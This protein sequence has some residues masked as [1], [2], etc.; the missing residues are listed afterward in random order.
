MP[1]LAICSRDLH[2]HWINWTLLCDTMEVSMLSRAW[3]TIAQHVFQPALTGRPELISRKIVSGEPGTKAIAVS[4]FR[5]KLSLANWV[6]GAT[7]ISRKIS[8]SW[9]PKKWGPTC[10]RD[11]SNSAIYTTVIY[12]AYIVFCMSFK[13]ISVKLLLHLKSCNWFRIKKYSSK[14]GS[15]YDMV[16]YNTAIMD[17]EYRSNFELTKIHPI[18]RLFRQTVGCLL[19]LCWKRLTVACIMWLHCTEWLVLG[20]VLIFRSQSNYR[21]TSDI[22]CTLVCNKIVDHSDVVGASPVSAAPTT[23]S[24]LTEH[25]ASLDRAKTTARRDEKH[26]RFEIWCDLYKRLYGNSLMGYWVT[27]WWIRLTG[28]W[29]YMQPLNLKVSDANFVIKAS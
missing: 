9:A 7:A 11:I 18:A 28:V 27:Y 12:R 23:S 4:R 24:Y 3:L 19:W 5:E 22:S 6:Q 20:T 29:I 14:V 16:A 21:K 26:L 10:D 25:L 8:R 1:R 17:I 15:C 13:I 2:W